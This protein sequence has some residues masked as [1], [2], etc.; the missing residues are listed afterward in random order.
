MTKTIEVE[1][2]GRRLTSA[3][4]KLARRPSAADATGGCRGGGRQRRCCVARTWRQ[5]RGHWA[6]TVARWRDTFLGAGEAPLTA[7]PVKAEELETDRLKT[8]V[9]ELTIEGE[10]LREKIARLETG[11]PL[12]LV[13]SKR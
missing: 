10:L 3:P 12:C 1:R 7:K 2:A 6:A 9:G 8:K 11:R 4:G 5:C 13:E